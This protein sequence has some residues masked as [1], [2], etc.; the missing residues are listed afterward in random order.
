MIFNFLTLFQ[1]YLP[2]EHY[3]NLYE[4]IIKVCYNYT[5][6]I[7][8]ENQNEF[9]TEKIKLTTCQFTALPLN[10]NDNLKK[11]VEM[12]LD[13]DNIKLSFPLTYHLPQSELFRFRKFLNN[14]ND[15]YNIVDEDKKS[16]MR[17]PLIY[18]YF[19][20]FRTLYFTPVTSHPDFINMLF[21]AIYNIEIIFP[22]KSK[23]PQMNTFRLFFN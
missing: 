7:P 5:K 9:E 4:E 12:N 13:L 21:E 8:S 14:A 16:Q 1:K 15:G 20:Y 23:S 3:D 19:V 17:E 10:L 22:V 6:Y 11:T 2:K 18:L